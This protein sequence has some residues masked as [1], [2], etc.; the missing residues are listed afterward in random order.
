MD[1]TTAA[2]ARLKATKIIQKIGYPDWF[3]IANGVENYY[4]GLGDVGSQFFENMVTVSLWQGQKAYLDL[5]NPVDKTQWEMFP[6]D[7]NAYYQASF[8]E[9]VFP[10]G[11][12]QPPFF[13]LT[14]QQALNYGGIGAVMG[15][16]ISHAFDDA[17]AQYDSDGN[18][19]Q[20]WTNSSYDMF[21]KKT[22]CF[23][24][25]Y[26]KLAV[27]GPNGPMQ[28]NGNLTL[29]E[30][31]ADNGGLRAAF[32]AYQSWVARNAPETQLPGLEADPN[33]LFFLGY[34]QVWCQNVSPDYAQ[35][36]V[37]SDSHSPSQYRVN[38]VVMNSKDFSAT[39]QCPVGSK[40]NPAE[41]CSVW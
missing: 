10:A 13:S 20:W 9:I 24:N 37:L 11:I 3:D 27:D 38:A 19:K 18:L 25:Q 22:T 23:A 35:M 7:V 28:I 34:A 8:N 17:G 12:L 40:M 36:A 1:A 2:A 39:F 30:N 21:Q 32:T 31:I 26:S 33:K 15:H 4:T 16:E 5:F 29:G 41:K 6:Q 14:A